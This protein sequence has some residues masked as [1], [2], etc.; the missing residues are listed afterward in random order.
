MERIRIGEKEY[1][2]GLVWRTLDLGDQA[3]IDVLAKESA[4]RYGVL[5]RRSASAPPEVAG[6]VANERRLKSHGKL[7]SAAAL[8]ANS[9]VKNC[10]LVESLDDGRYWMVGVRDGVVL[11]D[12][13]V[14]A[15][16]LR[17]IQERIHTLQSYGRFEVLGNVATQL[18]GEADVPFA[19]LILADELKRSTLRLVTSDRRRLQWAAVLLL[20]V[21]GTA[22]WW[23]WSQYQEAQAQRVSMA[24]QRARARAM[25][26][27][28][29]RNDWQKPTPT[30]LSA[31]A[32][33]LLRSTPAYIAE[34]EMLGMKCNTVN[35]AITWSNV[36][37][38]SLRALAARTG[39]PLEAVEY[40]LDGAK[41]V[42]GR[43][44]TPPTPSDQPSLPVSTEQVARLVDYAR[45]L[46]EVGVKMTVDKPVVV[47]F[48]NSKLVPTSELYQR[49]DWKAAG[50]A[51]MLEE[52][53]G[54]LEEPG[55]RITELRIAISGGAWD[56]EGYYVVR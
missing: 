9:V 45:R 29:L 7:V 34:W 50:K 24:E 38:G 28:Q 56:M 35:C 25:L 22:G 46:Q 27:T 16:D 47:S 39:T 36:G 30:M 5:I 49:G 10:I 18:G 6:F 44:I 55:V 23:G 12:T 32:G 51:G 13:D 43:T 54:L 40:S 14:V 41:A 33:E 37:R 26:Q 19:E 42:T 1:V 4:A 21:A 11:P 3:E 53:A 17:D 20:G 2:A 48:P 8:V 52:V 31:V 15:D